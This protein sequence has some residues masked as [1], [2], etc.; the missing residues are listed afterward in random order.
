MRVTIVGSGYIGQALARHWRQQ[1]D[2]Q[3]TLTTTS[4]TRVT[5]L[6]P[7]AERV[8][9]LRADDPAALAEALTD[10]EVAV[11]CLAPT[12]SSQVDA[13]GYRATYRDSFAAL[14]Q[15][16]PGLPRL[17]QLVYTAS[18]SVYG[19][20]GGAWVEETS[21][22]E[23]TD[24]H[25]RILLE[26][27]Q[28]LAACR[29]EARRV[30]LLRLGAIHGPGRQ[31]ADRFRRLAG[32]TRPG[33]GAH[34]CNWIHRDDVV[35]A[36]DAAVHQRWDGVVNLVDDHP[37]TVAALLQEVCDARG[38]APVQWD[39]SRQPEPLPAD[40][41]ISNRRLHQLGY[42]LRHPRLELPRLQTIDAPL[43]RAVADQAQ[44]SPRQRHTRNLHHSEDRVQRLLNVLQ[45]GTYVRPHR[46][47]RAEAGSGFECFVVLQGAIGL[48]LL[49]GRG[50]L[51]EC[52]RLEADGPLRGID[53]AEGQFHS[54]VALT[55]DAA[56][57]EIRQGPYRADTDKELLA[58]SPP[59]N[60]AEAAALE[61][62]W[63]RLFEDPS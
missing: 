54:L 58:G 26:S 24:D 17:R 61:L 56:I 33:N 47:R 6:A 19:D 42:R 32:T 25:G 15:V 11:F 39:P 9:V 57:F 7:L 8:A 48:L 49:D 38:L 51:L 60:S 21:P 31:L 50:E 14:Q 52:H 63:R 30:C 18:C 45:P 13:A 41:R 55:P 34:H 62:S 27:E 28:L 5:A 4:A 23:P 40:R 43:I 59:E 35:G 2:L 20:A 3:L 53:V 44:S 36:I 46:H 1:S 12:G 10:A 22:A 37:W 16:L 29:S